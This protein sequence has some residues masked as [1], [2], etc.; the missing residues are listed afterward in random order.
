MITTSLTEA[1]I[2]D[3][4][5]QLLNIHESLL[6][7]TRRNKPFQRA[8]KASITRDSHVLDIGSGSGLWAITAALLGAK[9]V[10]AIEREPMLIGLIKALA[11]AN[12]VADRVE[13][14]EG[15]SRHVQLAREFDVIVS[16]T[17]GHVIFDEQIAEIMVDARER[18][19][20][21]GGVLIPDSVTLMAAGARLA[22]HPAKLPSGIP[23]KLDY[24]ES[25]S[26][27][28]P[29]GLADK[30][31]IKL[32]TAAKPLIALD[33]HRV[34]TAPDLQSLAAAWP[35]CDTD[36]I[37]CFVVWAEATL[38]KGIEISTMKTSSWS[39]TAYRV[40]PF[41]AARGDLEFRLT[42]SSDTNYWTASLSADGQRQ[43]Q[44][45]SPAHAATELM[46]L[47]RVDPAMFEQ[48]KRM[49]LMNHRVA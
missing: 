12:G 32:L 23:G 30:K 39:V 45:Y 43:V 25:L 48:I 17:I 24:F 14:V 29:L 9:R 6:K 49:G 40:Q 38:A 3:H 26:L 1:Q 35:Q 31:P 34:T 36:G 27:N 44:S 20:K 8:L 10:V 7:D 13:V 21:P 41:A 22:G 5:S 2:H 4:V 37:N 15:D 46:A 19:L 42:L 16:E 33:L 47:T 18:F 11:H 28:N